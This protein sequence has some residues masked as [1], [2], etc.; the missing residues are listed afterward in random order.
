M[1]GP[2]ALIILD[3]YGLGEENEENAVYLANTPV[4]DRLFEQ[5]PH[6]TIVTSGEG[7]GLPEGQIGN[8]EVGH[9][10][11]GEGR[12]VY[13]ELSRISNTVADG[14]FFENPVLRETMDKARG[15]KKLHLIGLVSD[16]GVHSHNTHLYALLEMAR[17]HGL[18]NV[19]I[20]AFLDGRDVSP[21]SGAGYIRELVQKC[22][23]IGVGEIATIM[24]RYYAMDRDNRWDRVE[25]A[26]SAMVYGDAEFIPDA[27][28]AVE[29]SYENGVTDEF[30]LPA[31]CA[32]DGTIADGDSVIFFNFR[33]DR[34]RELT[35]ALTQA[36][37]GGFARRE[38]LRLDFIC[39]TQYDE[40]LTELPIA[41]PPEDTPG[42]V[43]EYISGLGL[44]QLRLAET[45]KYAHVTF[46][47]NGGREEPFPGED[48]VLIPSPRE[49][50]TYDLIPEMSARLV[51]D[52]AVSRI[53]GGDYDFI[54]INFA[55]C[56][57]V[58]HT[59]VKEA[60]VKAVEVVDECVG[61]VVDAVL[62]NNGFC[63][64]TADH[65]NADIM[66]SEDGSP[67]TAHTTNPAPL[68]AVGCGDIRLA[69]GRLADIMPTMLR[70]M[71]LE[72]P[73]FMTGECLIK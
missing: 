70:L 37:F 1:R 41:F 26:Y 71:E 24:G 32:R 25:L 60:A 19:Y 61:R 57:M 3:G 58:G 7:V 47:F 72:V 34:A 52:E 69:P 23:G 9:L 46:F 44:R 21:S 30:M 73:A 4:L 16:G 53:N 28:A 43:G 48:R 35:Y 6:S 39:M 55:N 51:T 38:R 62:S 59:G 67:H 14:T 12:V 22:A 65:G 45:E 31:V 18:R 64:I 63:L 5:A 66:R 54:V 11:I 10:N 68:I 15:D 49:Y 36:E 13:Q 42:T 40:K 2:A 56:D 17:R 33:P 27:A 8:S 20:H 50:A 29:R